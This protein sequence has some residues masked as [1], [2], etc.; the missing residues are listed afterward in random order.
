MPC[1]SRHSSTL[2]EWVR[3]PPGWETGRSRAAP[4]PV[5]GR[6]SRCTGL[7]QS[8]DK[9]VPLLAGK[10]QQF[11]QTFTGQRDSE[12]ERRADHLADPGHRLRLVSSSS[13]ICTNGQRKRLRALRLPACRRTGPVRGFPVPGSSRAV[14]RT[15]LYSAAL[16]EGA[17]CNSFFNSGMQEPQLVPHA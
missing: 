13:T 7:F 9:S 11:A 16:R 12:V 4:A 1:F 14:Q 3:W 17:V 5:W 10:A 8:V 15:H 6:A 2:C